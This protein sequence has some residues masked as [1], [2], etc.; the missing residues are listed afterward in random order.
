MKKA[1]FPYLILSLLLVVIFSMCACSLI[2]EEDQKRVLYNYTSEDSYSKFY[3]F[4]AE[5][6]SIRYVNENE[7]YFEFDVDY[8]Y[9]KQAYS[10]DDYTY[11]DGE[12]RW[13]GSYSTF[14]KEEFEIIPSS[15]RLLYEN[16]GYDLLQEGT[17]VIISANNY[18]GWLNWRYP[19]ISLEIDGTVY[20]DYETGLE[21]YLN[22]VKAGFK[23]P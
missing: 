16:G 18:E 10:Y 5:I 11:L 17:A 2:L 23:D 20:L 13:E 1:I 4:K 12:K 15:Y 19:I 3:T 8:D 6:R 9:F 21:N 7:K 22:Y 14:N